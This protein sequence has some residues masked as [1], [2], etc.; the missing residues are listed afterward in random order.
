MTSEIVP[1]RQKVRHLSFGI[2]VST[3]FIY[4][5]Q[6]ILCTVGLIDKAALQ[7]AVPR[8]FP[9]KSTSEG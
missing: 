3:R 2:A 4:G 5:G 7:A 9:W 1:V 6:Q 8:T